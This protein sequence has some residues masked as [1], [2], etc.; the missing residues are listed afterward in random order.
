M[1]A[2][3]SGVHKFSRRFQYQWLVAVA[4]VKQLSLPGF[5]LLCINIK[6]SRLAHFGDNAFLAPKR[7][8][9]LKSVIIT[10]EEK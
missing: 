2:L 6:F 7:C 10:S 4:Q 5:Y 9:S 3:T 1:H 8:P